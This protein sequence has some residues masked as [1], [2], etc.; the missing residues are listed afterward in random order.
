MTVAI[1]NASSEI[2]TPAA[3]AALSYNFSKILTKLPMK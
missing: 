2:F 1:E 3:E